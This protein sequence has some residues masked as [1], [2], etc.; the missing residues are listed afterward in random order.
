M[1]RVM[2]FVINK[3]NIIKQSFDFLN[4]KLE[5]MST[6]ERWLVVIAVP[7]VLALIVQILVIDGQLLTG[8]SLRQEVQTLETANA[9]LVI[10]L[11]NGPAKRATL[12]RQ[13]LGLQLERLTAEIEI[14]EDRL[15]NLSAAMISPEK[16]PEL[17]RT[18]LSEHSLSL[19]ALRNL[20]PEPVL[21]PELI[22]DLASTG[23][24]IGAAEATLYRHGIHLRLRGGY[25]E[26]LNYLKHLESQPLKV[27]WQ[28]MSYEVTD[29][30][31]GVLE[32]HL[33]TLGIDERWLGV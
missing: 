22:S 14:L 25:V 7:V 29:Y 19:V 13:N 15:G 4:E 28:S 30:P 9:A 21:P 26:V 6:R 2:T 31:E 11:Q 1:T 18:L 20:P 5:A 17:L 12:K 27:I 24:W 23:S 16:M 32:L 8:S 3:G 10:Q 33:Q